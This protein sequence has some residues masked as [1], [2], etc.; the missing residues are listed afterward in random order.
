MRKDVGKI[1]TMKEGM[2][3]RK[4]KKGFMTGGKNSCRNDLKEL[5]SYEREECERCQLPLRDKNV[6]RIYFC[7][8]LP[9]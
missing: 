4:K 3:R 2:R 1:M 8:H 6:T 9:T 7:L 5:L